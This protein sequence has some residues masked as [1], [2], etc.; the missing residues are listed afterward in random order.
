MVADQAATEFNVTW[1][2]TTPIV[3][4]C[5]DDAISTYITGASS[6]RM[7]MDVNGTASN[8]WA[9]RFA[10]SAAFSPL[11]IRMDPDSICSVTM[12]IGERI[13]QGQQN[14]S[15]ATVILSIKSTGISVIKN[16]ALSLL[17]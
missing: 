16:Q 5:V 15:T 11:K 8:V 12:G 17:P 6:L 1:T 4:S 14:C 7:G 9:F 2:R 3:V 10:C 13:L